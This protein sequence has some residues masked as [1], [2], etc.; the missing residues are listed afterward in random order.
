MKK[1][2]NYANAKHIA[3][4]VFTGDSEIEA[5]KVTV[6]DMEMGGQKL[7]STEELIAIVSNGTKIAKEA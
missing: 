5:G 3:Y 1:Q 7:V 2:M 4:A 6:K